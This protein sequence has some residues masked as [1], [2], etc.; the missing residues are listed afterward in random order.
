MPRKPLIYAYMV[1][2]GIKFAVLFLISLT[3]Y[4]NR[5]HIRVNQRLTW[6]LTLYLDVET[7]TNTYE[8][9]TPKW[10]NTNYV[11]VKR[12]KVEFTGRNAEIAI[13]TD[14]SNLLD[15]DIFVNEPGD[16]IIN[17]VYY[18]GWKYYVNGSEKKLTVSD[19]GMIK[20]W[21]EEGQYKIQAKWTETPLRQL[22]NII[23]I[24]SVGFIGILIIA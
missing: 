17:S 14:K 6:P 11:K 5:N 18:P 13:N 4:S 3:F 15:F 22:S 21:L 2:I 10:V 16:V 7:T 23:S 1:T 19:N 8:E 12:S 20:F 24:F 9:Y